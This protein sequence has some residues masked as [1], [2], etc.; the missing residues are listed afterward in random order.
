MAGRDL[1]GKGTWLGINKK[2]NIIA[3]LTNYN[4]EKWHDITDLKYGRG[5]LTHRFLKTEFL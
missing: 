5:N 4:C 2:T 1:E 3:F